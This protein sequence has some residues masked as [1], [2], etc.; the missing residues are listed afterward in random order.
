[1]RCSRKFAGFVLL[2][3]AAQTGWAQSGDAR[4]SG[5]VVDELGKPLS[6][7]TVLYTRIPTFARDAS[8]ALDAVSPPLSDAIKSGPNGRF[9]VP[10]LPAGEYYVC[11]QAPASGTIGSCEWNQPNAR[12]PLEGGGNAN[13][14]LRVRSG[15]RVLVQVVD[16]RESHSKE[17]I[18]LIGVMSPAG[19]YRRAERTVTDGSVGVYVATIPV[20]QEVSLFVHSDTVVTDSAGRAIANGQ[21]SIPIRTGG[22][23]SDVRLDLVLP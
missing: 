4:I 3:L 13:V 14:T 19:Y 23:Q 2:V 20:D 5:T 22:D 18:L 12:I 6:G 15:I 8:G 16:K 21:R 11:A 7:V 17:P 9:G 10:G 1:M